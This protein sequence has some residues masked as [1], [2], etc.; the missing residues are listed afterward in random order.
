MIRSWKIGAATVTSVAEYYGPVHIP[1]VLYPD[2]DRQVLRD[3][4]ALMEG[5]FWIEETDRLVIG[6]QIW[7]LRLGDRV[8]V[9]DTGIGNHKPRKTPRANMLN[10]VVM[11]WLAAAGATPDTVTEVLTT[12]LHND[13]TGWHCR[14]EGSDWVPTFPKAGYYL[15]QEDYDWFG[16]QHRAG[17]AKD[18]AFADSVEP[19]VAAGLATFVAPGDEV[20]GLRVT[21]A[22]GHTPG[23]VNYWLESEGRFGVFAGDVL[24]HPVQVLRP[25]WN[26]IVDIQPERALPTRA[27]FLAD[28]SERDALVMPCHFGPP[29]CGFVRRQDTGYRFDP[30]PPGA[31][32]P[33]R[34]EDAWR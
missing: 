33:A 1:D 14:L 8:I 3:N 27:R 11:D 7:V 28:V 15:P 31:A 30:A 26:S 5:P 34:A 2:M 9:V 13:H 21:A 12:H 17:K 32:V 23:M 19:V 18:N 6:I 20:A 16:A 10:T 24:H 25:E 29:H 22:G 4:R